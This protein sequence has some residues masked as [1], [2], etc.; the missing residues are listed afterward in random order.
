[1]YICSNDHIEIFKMKK[2]GEK[3]DAAKFKVYVIH[4]LHKTKRSAV[5]SYVMRTMDSSMQIFSAVQ[6]KFNS[7]LCIL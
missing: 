7:S 2:K 6:F 5:H 3:E 4:E 1:M